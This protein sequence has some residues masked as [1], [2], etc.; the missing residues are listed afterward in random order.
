MKDF[1]ERVIRAAR[2]RGI[3]AIS[4]VKPV[5]EVILTPKKRKELVQKAYE[6]PV[7]KQRF[8]QYDIS[9]GK[10]DWSGICRDT[11]CGVCNKSYLGRGKLYHLQ[12]CGSCIEAHV[13][14]RDADFVRLEKENAI[15]LRA[16]GCNGLSSRLN[17]RAEE[18]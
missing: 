6:N 11:T 12:I 9:E 4:G 5:K 3:V 17:S 7:L 10:P 15:T 16:Y 13:T 18:G 1:G 8:D 2:K 14:M